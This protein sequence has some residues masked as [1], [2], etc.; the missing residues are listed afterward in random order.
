[1]ENNTSLKASKK[2]M[3]VA[4]ATI[5]LKK[6]Q[7]YPTLNGFASYQ[8]FTGRKRASADTDWLKGYS[9]GISLNYEMFDGFSKDADIALAELDLLK[10]R[11]NHL[12]LEHDLKANLKKVLLSI[13]SLKSQ[14]KAVKASLS[15]AEES[16][17]LSTE[18]YKVGV[19]SQ[20]EVLES[21]ANY[22]NLLANYY[23]LLY[24]YNSAIA[25]LERLVQ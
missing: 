25:L 2:A 24:Q 6:A 11:E 7:R 4:K 16:L 13:N 12:Q 9:L 18:R 1:L 5:E 21:K 8:T 10:Q 15:A 23:F 19:A 20:T 17:R 22:N 3:E 14:I